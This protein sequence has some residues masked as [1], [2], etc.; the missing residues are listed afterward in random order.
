MNV[1]EKLYTVQTG[2][3]CDCF[4]T[5]RALEQAFHAMAV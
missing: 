5:G 2:F 3:V 4:L 1:S